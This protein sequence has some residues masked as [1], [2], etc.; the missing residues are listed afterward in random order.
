MK[1]ISVLIENPV[2]ISSDLFLIK[3]IDLNLSGLSIILL[4]E[5]QFISTRIL[6]SLAKLS[7]LTSFI[8]T[9]GFSFG[10]F[11]RC[12]SVLGKQDKV[13]SSAKL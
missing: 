8:A 5:N 1:T 9:S 6:E 11:I 10:A 2:G 13:L 7:S 12:L 3:V 4:L